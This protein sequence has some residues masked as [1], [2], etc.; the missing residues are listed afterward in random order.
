LSQVSQGSERRLIVTWKSDTSKGILPVAELIIRVG[1]PRYR[2]GYLE[3]AREALRFGF[4]PFLA[5]P[6]PEARYE[7]EALF[8]FFANR[9]LPTTRPDYLESLTAVGLDVRDVSVAE[10]LGRTNGR[11][12]TD[13]IETILVPIRNAEGRYR[14]HFLLRGVNH[15][16]GAE[17][18]IATLNPDEPLMLVRDTSNEYNPHARRLHARGHKLGYVPD[19]LVEDLDA[20]ERA[21]VVPAVFGERVNLPPQPAHY[22][23]LCRI[24]CEWP[25]D[26]VPFQDPRLAPYGNREA[27]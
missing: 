15:T 11:R 2:F 17:E 7:S 22:R 10:V 5:F 9:V 16:P 3:G 12:A 19:Y 8:P 24:D 21:G 26:F 1:A 23:L 25:P 18:I 6:N 13:R 20:L 14:T 27:A 4:Q